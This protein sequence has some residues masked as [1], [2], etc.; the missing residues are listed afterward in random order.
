[1]QAEADVG[2]IVRRAFPGCRVGACQSLAGGISARPVLVE[3]V[4][5]DQTPRRVVVRRP[6][7]P[8][9]EETLRRVRAEYAALGRCAALGIAAPPPCFLDLE[10]SALVLEYVAG[11]PEFTPAALERSAGLEQLAAQLARIHCIPGSAELDVLPR[12]SAHIE[13]NLRQP[14][15]RLDESLG[16]ARLRAA[17]SRLGP[18]QP[19]QAEVLLHGDYWPGNVLWREGKLAAVLDWEEAALGEPLADLGVSRLDILWA[20]GAEAMSTFT[21]SYAEH[22]E[23][24]AR[25]LARWDLC[26]ALR[27]MSDL[28][29]WAAGYARPPICRPDITESSMREGHRWFVEQALRSLGLDG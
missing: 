26:A 1:M 19:A 28:P 3:I 13:Q 14:P 15:A 24:D 21:R 8:T 22:A 18:W 16:E 12:R 11:A 10:A 20:F 23:I 4:L 25:Q 17:L 5:G 29:R 2:A 27:P 7:W 6:T 9:P